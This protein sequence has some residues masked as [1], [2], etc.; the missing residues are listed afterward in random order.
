M[1][2]KYLKLAQA[3]ALVLAGFLAISLVFMQGLLPLGLVDIP[4][5]VALIA[6]AI[7][8]PLL[9]ICI[10]IR[11][12]IEMEVFLL[13]ATSY[14]VSFV[15]AFLVTPVG[16]VAAFWHISWYIGVICLLSCLV[17]YITVYNIGGHL[18]DALLKE[19]QEQ[20]PKEGSMDS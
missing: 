7:A 13:K 2:D 5:T 9:A 20:K 4:V 10:F 15:T 16:I 14:W 17:A 3:D 8:I 18:A 11:R 19:L 1:I 6:F 12:L